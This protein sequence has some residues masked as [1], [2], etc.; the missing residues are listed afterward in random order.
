MYIKY[1]ADD[2]DP[3]SS[4]ITIGRIKEEHIALYQSV[5]PLGETKPVSV[6]I[7]M[8]DDSVPDAEEI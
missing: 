7:L 4:Q 5:P 2:C 3:P 6:E 1:K 8:L